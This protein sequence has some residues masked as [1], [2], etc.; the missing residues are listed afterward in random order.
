MVQTLAQIVSLVVV[1]YAA[2]G[3][4]FALAFAWRGA[5]RID[6]AA[7]DATWGF[8]VLVVPGAAALWPLLAMRW[9]RH[10]T[11]PIE[12]TPHRRA[13]AAAHE[14]SSAERPSAERPL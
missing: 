4:L 1:L 10:T 8:R 5:A 13:A 6:P 7:D 2:L 3:L 9:A 14:A 12:D 11:P